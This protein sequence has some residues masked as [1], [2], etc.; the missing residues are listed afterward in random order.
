[1]K[2]AIVLI[3][4]LTVACATPA[5]AADG[6]QVSGSVRLRFEGISG[7][8]RPAYNE[9]DQLLL[10]RTFLQAR[11][12]QNSWRWVAELQDSRAWWGDSK[13]LLGTTDVNAL[14]LSQA[15]VAHDVDGLLGKGSRLTLQAG[16]F[17][18]S[19]GSRRLIAAE[20][21]R[22]TTTSMTGVRTDWQVPSTAGGTV[23]VAFPSTR[24]PDSTDAL[25]R[26]DIKADRESLDTLFYG[27]QL[28]SAPR[29]AGGV[30]EL[31]LV[32][33]RD[34]D[35]PGRPSRDRDLRTV[36]LRLIR[37]PAAGRWDWDLEAA[38]QWGQASSTTAATAVR[39][40]VAANFLHLRA[41]YQW[42]RAWKPRVALDYDWA[43]GDGSGPVSHRFD[44]LYGGRRSDFAPSGLYALLGRA[45]IS[46]PGLRVEATPSARLD[47][48]ATVRGLWLA[49]AVDAFSTTGIR[50]AAGSAGSY[51]G[52][53]WDTRLRYWLVPKR[54]QLEVN[55]LLLKHG[56]FLQL[57]PG[58]R[59]ESETRF[60]AVS[61]MSSF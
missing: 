33:L 32:G 1:M 56:H 25:L 21:F 37:E 28:R 6:L 23:F 44:T 43:S 19:M 58:A 16:R 59:R 35:A 14:E 15:Y 55:A 38:L 12:T 57:A 13:T 29:M 61:V 39:R 46:T 20:D 24:L 47:V 42:D 54:L 22:N 3:S 53:Q 7:Q 9:D 50:D 5:L 11:F 17:S 45:N 49:S 8:P 52:M 4:L 10:S 18:M 60:L 2:P 31:L 41:G 36:D 34:R 40:E 30:V 26:N 48:M 51:A 27:A